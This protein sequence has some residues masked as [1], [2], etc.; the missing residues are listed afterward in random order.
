LKLSTSQLAGEVSLWL[1]LLR[2]CPHDELRGDLLIM[3][4][5]DLLLVFLFFLSLFLGLLAGKPVFLSPLPV[6][7]LI[8]S[9]LPIMIIGVHS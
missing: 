3:T 6:Y 4:L 2:V 8:S 5:L 1:A 9:S 7:R